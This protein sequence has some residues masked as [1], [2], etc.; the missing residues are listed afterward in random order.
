MSVLTCFSLVGNLAH[1][2]TRL[3]LSNERKETAGYFLEKRRVKRKGIKG[4]RNKKKGENRGGR[5][6]EKEKK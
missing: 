3:S 1:N 6:K 4:S 5:R 2:A